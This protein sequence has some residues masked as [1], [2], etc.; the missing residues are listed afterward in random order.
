[1]TIKLSLI[2]MLYSSL[3]HIVY[4]FSQ[5]LTR[6]FLVTAPKM[7]VHLP[8]ASAP[9]LTDPG[10]ELT[11]LSKSSQSHIATDGHSVSKSWWAHDHIFITVLTVTV[12]FFMGRPL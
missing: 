10:T 6:R 5:S 1:M 11:K 3:E 8:S 2:S 12:L 9:L 7:A 4:E